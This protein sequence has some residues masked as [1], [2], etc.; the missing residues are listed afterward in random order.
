[1]SL[2]MQ[3][4]LDVSATFDWQIADTMAGGAVCSAMG[5][6]WIFGVARRRVE[7]LGEDIPGWLGYQSD[8]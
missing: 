2:G 6:I 7:V 8:R 5:T 1:M 3:S 4:T